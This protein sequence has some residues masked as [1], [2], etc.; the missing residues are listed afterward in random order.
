MPSLDQQRICSASQEN[1]MRIQWPVAWPILDQKY[2]DKGG[3]VQRG[4]SEKARDSDRQDVKKRNNWE[5]HTAQ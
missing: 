2:P 1:I 3:L 5:G 4:G